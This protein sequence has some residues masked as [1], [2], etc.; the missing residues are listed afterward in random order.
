LSNQPY[1]SALFPA[2]LK[3]MG[4]PVVLV[5]GG[6]VAIAKHAGLRAAGA[7]VTVVAPRIAPALRD[8]ETVLIERPFEPA[9]LGEAWFV[10]AAAAPEVNRAVLVAAESRRLFVNAVDDPSAATAYAGGVVRRGAVTLAIST[11]GEAPALAGLLREALE[12][13]LPDDLTT[14]LATARDERERWRASGAPME[15]R[16]P[17]LLQALNRLYQDDA[18]PWKS[19][20]GRR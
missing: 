3:L 1:N 17:L 18:P 13:V 16:R 7:R 14:W 9:D 12:A 19:V 4:R 6:R 11:G 8:A 20:E 15:R 5:G 10:V 2:F